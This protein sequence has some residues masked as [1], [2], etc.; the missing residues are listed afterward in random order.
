MADTHD[1]L[2]NSVIIGAHPDD[3]LLWFTSILRKV[4]EVIILYRDIWSEPQMGDARAAA[5]KAYPRGNVRFLEMAE[6]GS[7]DCA[8]WTNPKPGPFGMEFGTEGTR[9]KAKRIVKKSLSQ[10][11]PGSFRHS[12]RPIAQAYRDNYETLYRTL[13]PLLKPDMNVFTH[14]PWGEYGHEDHVQVFRVLDR[15][16]D[17]IGFKL[18]MSNYCTERSMPLAMQYFSRRPQ[19]YIRLPADKGFAEQVAN[20]YRQHGCWTWRDDW[21]WFDDECFMEAPSSKPES[22]GF[23]LLPMNLFNFGTVVRKPVN[24]SLLLGTALSSVVVGATIAAALE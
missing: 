17:E 6:T 22:G 12:T 14:N 9:R 11:M 18:W 5:I 3:E 1:F 16:R 13:L 7:F 20:I 8:D 21:I 23:H 10:I 4:D 24:T 2:K 15:L 19:D